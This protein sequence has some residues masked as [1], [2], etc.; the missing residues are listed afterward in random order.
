MEREGQDLQVGPGS[1][2]G[3][4]RLRPLLRVRR[5]D[6]LGREE[7]EGLR[8]EVKY[9]I[10]Y[11]PKLQLSLKVSSPRRSKIADVQE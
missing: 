11:V 6:P 5:E 9:I 10:K 2:Q 8:P 1:V 4:Q 3:Q 7:D